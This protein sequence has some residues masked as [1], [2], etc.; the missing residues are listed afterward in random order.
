MR[1]LTEY[2]RGSIFGAVLLGVAFAA[3]LSTAPGAKDQAQYAN[4]SEKTAEVD[5][6]HQKRETI[7]KATTH[8][9][10][11]IYTLG[12][13][14]VAA[15]QAG[16]FWWQ[17][18]FMLAGLKDAAVAANAAKESADASREQAETAKDAL[19]V[20]RRPYVFISGVKL[21]KLRLDPLMRVKDRYVEYTVGNYGSTPAIV[22]EIRIDFLSSKEVPIDA[23]DVAW[24]NLPIFDCRVISGGAAPVSYTH[25][26]PDLTVE[27]EDAPLLRYNDYEGRG[28]ASFADPIL[29]GGFSFFFRVVILY[30]GP[31]TT[32][33]ETSA[34]WRYDLS[35]N[36]FVIADPATNYET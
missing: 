12:L 25:D 16:L 15:V 7:W 23:P 13:L 36:R 14:I 29:R 5:A 35:Q 6:Q 34:C 22:S 4:S 1:G 24:D 21:L 33:H 32:N 19:T 26:A 28:P 30:R 11:A 3:A 20:A 2:Q 8:D 18:G 17:L 27:G 10:I 31:F 9:P